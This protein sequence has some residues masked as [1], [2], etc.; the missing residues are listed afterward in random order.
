[1]TATYDKIAAYTVPSAT[2]SYTF[3][4]ISSAYT[5]LVLIAT[6]AS[7]LGTGYGFRMRFNSDSG[8]NYSWTHLFGTGSAA[9]SNRGSNDSSILIGYSPAAIGGN[10]I[11]TNIQ[12]YSNS[13]TN[14]TAISRASEADYRVGAIAGLWRNT[15][16][17]TSLTLLDEG[18]GNLLTGSTFT[19]YGIKAA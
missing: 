13:T 12:N 3:T 4:S 15:A 5:D 8:S 16:A 10:A 7:S 14:K 11:I 2:A 19:L 18:G 9:N 6:S 1:M 17:I